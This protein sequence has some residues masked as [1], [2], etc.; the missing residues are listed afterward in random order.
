MESYLYSVDMPY[1]GSKIF[2]REL[3]VKEQLCLSKAHVRLPLNEEYAED[4]SRVLFEVVRGCVKNKKDFDQLN[5]IDYILFLCKLRIISIGENLEL[6]SEE[7]SLEEELPIKIKLNVN[8]PHMMMNLYEASKILKDC[9]EIY[10]D[11]LK[12]KLNWPSLKCETFFVKK[13]DN[14]LLDSVALFIENFTLNNKY[15]D[16]SKYSAEQKIITFDNFPARY[17]IKIQ[18]IVFEKLK[19]FIETDIFDEKLSKHIMFNFYNLSYQMMLRLF[20][21]DNLKK[22]YHQYYI[23]AS[24]NLLPSYVDKIS[25]A[26]KNVFYSFIEEEYENSEQSRHSSQNEDEMSIEHLLGE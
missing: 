2:Y 10:I 24:R 9:E 19:T 4:Y 23:F 1:Y 8:L 26:E 20:F 25:I 3:N 6:Q 22:L 7:K 16:L 17:Q 18:E 5:I 14:K 21:A 15:F 11:Q 13:S 12:V